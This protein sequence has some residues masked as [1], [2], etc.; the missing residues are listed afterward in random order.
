MSRDDGFLSRW[1]RRKLERESEPPAS[2]PAAARESPAPDEGHQP[3]SPEDIAQLPRPEDLTIDSEIGPFLRAGVPQGLRNAALRRMWSLDPVIR[4]YVG[5]ARDYAYDWNVPGGV[6]GGGTLPSPDEIEATLA[7]MFSRESGEK[8]GVAGVSE[9]TNEVRLAVPEALSPSEPAAASA[10]PD[11]VQT[12]PP[13]PADRRGPSAPEP[14]A[15]LSATSSR[16]RHGG[17]TPG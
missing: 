12:P 17:A 16:R 10:V 5:D 1:S 6:P 9:P 13:L 15:E 8:G 11:Q 7:R 4:D 3:L 2:V 14:V